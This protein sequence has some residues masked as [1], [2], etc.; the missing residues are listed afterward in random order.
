MNKPDTVTA[1]Y[2]L[3][4][5]IESA[6]PFDLSEAQICSGLCIGC[7]KKLLEYIFI[8]LNQWKIALADGEKPKLGDIEKLA[9]TGKKIYRV[10]ELN[11]LV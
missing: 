7:S 4:D 10:L 6:M 9:K 5:Q 2:Q 1:M 8:E 3:L 11:H